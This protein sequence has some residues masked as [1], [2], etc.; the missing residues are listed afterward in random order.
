MTCQVLEKKKEGRR[1]SLSAPSR[2]LISNRY[3]R[4]WKRGEGDECSR[5]GG[6]NSEEKVFANKST[7]H[8][9]SDQRD[10]KKDEG[11]KGRAE[12]SGLKG[13][14][15]S[16]DRF[17]ELISGEGGKGKTEADQPRKKRDITRRAGSLFFAIF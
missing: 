3:S 8:P 16:R 2:F 17:I 7:L 11:R 10:R 9:T 14:K 4:N 12:P 1:A 6:N 5:R 13:K 15:S